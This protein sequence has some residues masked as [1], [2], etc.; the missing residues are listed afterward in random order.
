MEDCVVFGCITGEADGNCGNFRLQQK[1]V[2]EKG[3]PVYRMIK[4][5][6]ALIFS[7][8]N[9]EFDLFILTVASVQKSI[10]GKC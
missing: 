6:N 5:D 7:E 4:V 2:D 9:Q 1:G 10:I 8:N 3:D